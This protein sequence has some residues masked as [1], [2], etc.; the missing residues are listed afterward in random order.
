M[1]PRF[2]ID[3]LKE[4]VGLEAT[5]RYGL[6]TIV[7]IIAN[8]GRAQI[9]GAEDLRTL[10]FGERRRCGRSASVRHFLESMHGRVFLLPRERRY[11]SRR[12]HDSIHVDRYL[13]QKATR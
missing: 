10:D 8:P 12:E 13:V 4:F 5:L 11:L 9:S 3:A 7:G 6:V 2:D 1:A